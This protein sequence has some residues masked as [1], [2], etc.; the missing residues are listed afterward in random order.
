MVVEVVIGWAN[1]RM[2][3]SLRIMAITKTSDKEINRLT[4]WKRPFNL[5]LFL[6]IVDS[7]AEVL[8][9]YIDIGEEIESISLYTMCFYYAFFCDYSDF[10]HSFVHSPFFSMFF[11]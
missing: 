1:G 2:V 10:I 7:W 5:F 11:D 3:E 4:R 9:M 8:G 6:N